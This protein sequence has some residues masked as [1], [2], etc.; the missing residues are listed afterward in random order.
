M[1]WAQVR[2][3]KAD[4]P[5][6]AVRLKKAKNPIT[7]GFCPDGYEEGNGD[8]GASVPFTLTQVMKHRLRLYGYSDEEIA[9]LT[10]QKAHEILAG[11]GD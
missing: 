9:H 7:T 1:K 5:T 3:F 10:P 6:A 8:Q 2:I 4:S 11:G